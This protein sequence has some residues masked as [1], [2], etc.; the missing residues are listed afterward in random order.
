MYSS[1]ARG[2]LLARFTFSY[3]E[4]GNRKTIFDSNGAST[5]YTY[6]AKN[7]LTQDA[8]AGTNAHTYNYSY[9]ATN[10]RL[11]SNETGVVST[12]NYDAA[13]RL[14]T[15]TNGTL[16]TTYTFDANGNQTIVAVQGSSP[17]TMAY[18]KENRMTEYNDA[19]TRT[20]YTYSGDGLKR[21]EKDG[22]GT[23]TLVWDGSDY[24]QGRN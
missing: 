14:T 21:S 24:L 6:D 16:V 12:F 1:S 22:S 23:T 11:T 10:N 4:V 3:D 19:G 2:T 15:S 8:T 9:D 18:D 7:R 13:S 20:T 17:V 5:T